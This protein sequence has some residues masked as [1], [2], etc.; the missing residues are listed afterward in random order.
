[1]YILVAEDT[2]PVVFFDDLIRQDINHHLRVP[3]LG[4]W[5]FEVEVFKS[6]VMKRAPG[7]EMTELNRSFAVV[8]SNVGALTS[9][10]QI[11]YCRRQLDACGDFLFSADG[12]CKKCV[13]T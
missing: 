11:K 9:Y 10:R 7:V 3:W 5:C 12:T 13:Y 6:S 4:Q 8:I 2:T 1:M